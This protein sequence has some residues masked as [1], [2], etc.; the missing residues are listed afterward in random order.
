[1]SKLYKI[2]ATHVD[3]SK[4]EHIV[5]SVKRVQTIRNAYHEYTYITNVEVTDLTLDK[6]AFDVA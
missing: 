6:Y 2:V 4:L 5:D 3:G 1:M